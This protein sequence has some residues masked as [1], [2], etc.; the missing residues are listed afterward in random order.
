MHRACPRPTIPAPPDL[1]LLTS[2]LSRSLGPTPHARLSRPPTKTTTAVTIA[3]TIPS[4]TLPTQTSSPSPAPPT[5][6]P[7]AIRTPRAGRLREAASSTSA[8]VPESPPSRCPR[9]NPLTNKT[10]SPSPPP[11]VATVLRPITQEV[12]VCLD[13]SLPLGFSSHC[14]TR[15]PPASSTS[16]FP[17]F[18]FAN[19]RPFV[20]SF[21]T[22][23]FYGQDDLQRPNLPFSSQSQISLSSAGDTDS[24]S[25]TGS[26]P[27][28]SKTFGLLGRSKSNRDKDRSNPVPAPVTLPNTPSIPVLYDSNAPLR[29]APVA[30]DRAFREMMNSSI[31]N[32]S[33]DRALARDGSSSRENLRDRDNHTKMPSS[34]YKENGGSTFLSGLRGSRAVDIFSKGLFG[35]SSRSGSTTEKEP[36]VDDEHYVIKVL[37]LP[38]VKQARLTRISK[39][40][41]HSRDKTEFWMP[42]F[43]WRAIDYL[44][45]KG[46]DVE[47]LYR[48]PGSG[49]QIKKWQ[50]RFDERKF[51][52]P[53]SHK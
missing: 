1:L 13:R 29:T 35:K 42:A 21:L 45:Y 24:A 6:P 38:L 2:A 9:L 3:R 40:L 53:F 52:L 26:K 44:N 19:T 22:G 49:P 14:P 32:R 16:S 50:R 46:C 34:S 33:E 41:E 17:R 39:R 7:L 36:V 31:R 43:P 48:V 27:R 8:R 51:Y 47:G 11:G 12:R 10:S 25:A 18:C 4:R 20:V 30:Q 28:K 5:S 37:N 23:S 15:S